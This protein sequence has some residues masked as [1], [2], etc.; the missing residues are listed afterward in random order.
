MSA[1]Q[2]LSKTVFPWLK[3]NLGKHC[4][5]VLTGQDEKAL[6]AA[7]TLVPL[8]CNSD[9]RGAVAIAFHYVVLEMQPQA[10]ELAFHA[11]AHAAD[12]GHRQ[13]LWSQACL[14]LPASVRVCAFGPGGNGGAS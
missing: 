8:W 14:D 13:E 2:P 12:W 5:G 3:A 4:L 10:R 6:A 11:I 1:A 7:V 9:D